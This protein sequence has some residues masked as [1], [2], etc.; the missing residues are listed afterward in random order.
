[1]HLARYWEKGGG[2]KSKNELDS[3]CPQRLPSLAEK[4]VTLTNSS[5]PGQIVT[6]ANWKSQQSVMGS[7]RQ[8]Q[9]ITGKPGRRHLAATHTGLSL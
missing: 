6:E 4:T 5:N 9:L 7:Q 1:M 2:E 3:P 8:E